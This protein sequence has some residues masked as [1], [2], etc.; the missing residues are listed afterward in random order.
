MIPAK[1]LLVVL[2]AKHFSTYGQATTLI[3]CNIVLK[4]LDTTQV[5]TDGE[6]KAICTVRKL[7]V[8]IET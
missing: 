4:G 3:F 5:F 6:T 1:L 2:T 7:F 8:A